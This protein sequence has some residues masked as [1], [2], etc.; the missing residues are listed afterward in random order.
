MHFDN[1]YARLPERFHTHLVP[2][3]V[4]GPALIRINEALSTQLGIDPDWLKSADGVAMMAGNRLPEGTEPIA[5]VYAGHQFGNFNPQLGDGRAILLGEVLDSGNERFD[6]QLKGAGP[7]PYSRQGDGRAPLG[8]VLREYLISEAMAAMGVPTSRS[9]GAVTTGDT[10][11]REQ[12]E[13]GAVLTRIAKS[14]IR[15]GTFEF[16]ASRQDTGAIS[17]L[18]EHVLARHYPD[19]CD[20]EN[21]GLTLLNAAIQSQASLVAQWQC[22]GFIHGVMNTDNMLLCGETIDYGP[23]AFM[24]TYHPN[25]V[26]SSIDHMGRYQY[27]NQPPIAH[28][29]LASLAQ[30]LLSQLSKDEKT[31]V[32]LAQNAINQFPIV[33]EETWYQIMNSKLG[34]SS[35]DRSLS[36]DFLKLLEEQQIDYTLAFRT[37][38]DLAEDRHHLHDLLSLPESPVEQ[39]FN[40]GEPAFDAWL[41]RWRSQ[42]DPDAV[43]GLRERNPLVIPRNHLVEAAISSA[44]YEEDFEPFNLLL[45]RIIRPFDD[46]PVTPSFILPPR[47]DEQVTRTFCGT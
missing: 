8:P 9:L 23:C 7:T 17:L 44:V 27:C 30:T 40:P 29:N 45:D 26:F 1:S 4:S 43:S 32:S 31:A 42:L 3:P 28:W 5:T 34:I 21:P 37:L 22:I 13:P 36:T 19:L 41:K 25:T 24:D 46:L 15:I 38:C 11:Y 10:V 39:A 12:A 47:A 18:T 14:H 33:Y 16:F 6:L 35:A 20:S 2:T